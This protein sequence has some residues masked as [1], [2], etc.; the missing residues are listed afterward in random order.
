MFVFFKMKKI[1]Q[2]DVIKEIL[3]LQIYE[4]GLKKFVIFFK[5]NRNIYFYFVVL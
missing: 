4:I 1:F 2:I 5:E 3:K